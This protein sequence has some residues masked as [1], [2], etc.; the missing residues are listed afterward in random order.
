MFRTLTSDDLDRELETEDSP[1]ISIEPSEIEVEL[2]SR[3]TA[4]RVRT[5]NRLQGEKD[6]RDWAREFTVIQPWLQL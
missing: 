1:A 2:L 3:S 6:Q 4:C 5:L